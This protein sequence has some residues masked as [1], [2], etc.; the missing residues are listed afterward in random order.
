MEKKATKKSSVKKC[1][2]CGGPTVRKTVG[3][4]IKTTINECPKGCGPKALG[5]LFKF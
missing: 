2:Q 1:W 3:N 5:A 4:K